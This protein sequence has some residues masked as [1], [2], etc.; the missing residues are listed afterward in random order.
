MLHAIL[1]QLQ[2]IIIKL[3]LFDEIPSVVLGTCE[4]IVYGLWLI[5]E[6]L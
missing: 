6:Q 1:N 3:T 4:Y 2:S 5:F